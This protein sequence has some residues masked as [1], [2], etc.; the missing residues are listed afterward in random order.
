[1]VKWLKTKNEIINMSYVRRFSLSYL[2]DVVQILAWFDDDI[3]H[4]I[5]IDEYKENVMYEIETEIG[6]LVECLGRD[7]ALLEFSKIERFV[8][9]CHCSLS[10]VEI[11]DS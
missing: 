2:G 8:D 11:Y 4:C 10:E 3:E 6:T 9:C 1:M 7:C 5:V